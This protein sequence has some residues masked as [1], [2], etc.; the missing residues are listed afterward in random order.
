MRFLL[1]PALAWLSTLDA[2]QLIYE[3]NLAA[4][5]VAADPRGNA[6]VATGNSVM[7]FNPDGSVAYSKALTLRG[8]WNAMA[9]DASGE[10]FIAGTTNDDSLPG[11][12]GAFQPNRNSSGK[13]LTLDKNSTPFPCSDAF[14]AKV[15]ANGNLAWATYLGGNAIEL[16]TGIAVDQA[17]NAYV[18]GM[19]QSADFPV[20]GGFQK[21]FGG[22]ADAFVTKISADGTRILYSSFI[23]G[24]LHDIAHGVAVDTNGNAY[25]VGEGGTGIP[26]TAGSFGPTCSAL[27]GFLLKV[28]PAGDR[29]IFGG[30]A[31]GSNRAT[32]MTA[33]T[34]DAAGNVYVG[35]DTN[36]PDFPVTTTFDARSKGVVQSDFILKVSADGQQF[37]YSALLDGASFGIYSLGV[38]ARGAVYAAGTTSSATMPVTGPALQPCPGPSNLDYNFLLKLNP[39]G[40]ALNY[41]SFDDS[42]LLRINIA[43]TPDGAVVEGAGLVRKLTNLET[44]GDPYASKDCVL[45]GA[46]FVSHTQFG[47]PGISP[48]EIVTLKGTTLGP[49]KGAQF[50][51]TNNTVGTSLGQTQ[52]LFDG[53]PAPL[54]YVQDHQINVLAPYALSGKTQTSIVVQSQ[55]HASPAVVIPVSQTST[56][57]FVNFSTFDPLVL[58]Q[59]F[60]L[61]AVGNAAARGTSI[62]LYVTGAGQTSPASTDGEVWQSQAGLAA[63]TSAKIANVSPSPLTSTLPVLYAGP[64][65][66]FISGLQ[67]INLQIPSDLP[68][69]FVSGVTAGHTFV[70]VTTGS[71]TFTVPVIV[72]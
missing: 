61:N 10:V 38:D 40:S 68:V 17:G 60:S 4:N 45:N 34:V 24:V 62:V 44:E 16:G 7:K 29:L 50:T 12:P 53:I 22:D 23:G 30:C 27:S 21:Q 39:A 47:Q 36:A 32:S 51:L 46:S 56:A 9:V 63:A 67:Q 18:V 70:T 1:I 5:L 65:P 14:V 54:L 48:G 43:V 28:A 58:N 69:P 33:V 59:D 37:L 2:A 42:S 64:A 13:C 3:K 55:G 66:G 35:G 25:V 8:D 26:V 20:S 57:P 71:Q 11:T 31:G 52:V 15:D 49:A 19:T 72:K 6:Y 41:F